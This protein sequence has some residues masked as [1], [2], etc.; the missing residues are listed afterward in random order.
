MPELGPSNS[1]GEVRKTK[2]PNRVK[3]TEKRKN[4]I[5]DLLD[6]WTYETKEFML[7]RLEKYHPQFSSYRLM[8]NIWCWFMDA[9]SNE[10]FKLQC[11][12]DAI[13]AHLYEISQ[14][15]LIYILDRFPIARNRDIQR[16][17]TYRTKETILE[18][19][20]KIKILN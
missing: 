17:G 18:Y 6:H 12:L 5:E 11:Q 3:I 14:E 19:F 20:N 4:Q 7:K 9:D 8:K 1:G 2:E 16:F 10:R 15:E 13:Y